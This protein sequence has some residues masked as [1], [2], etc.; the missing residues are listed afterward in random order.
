MFVAKT[1]CFRIV[2]GIIMRVGGSHCEIVCI[3]ATTN[4]WVSSERAK[5]SFCWA[6]LLLNGLPVATH[7]QTVTPDKITPPPVF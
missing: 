5:T 2:S 7:G 3:Q 1:D 6:M 4:G